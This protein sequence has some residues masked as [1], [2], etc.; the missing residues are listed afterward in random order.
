MKTEITPGVIFGECLVDDFGTAQ[1]LGG[2]P[3]NVA[4]HLHALGVASILVSRVGRDASGQRILQRMRDW[5]MPTHG[6]LEDDAL[7]TGR[8]RVIVDARQGHRFEILPH[9]AYDAISLPVKVTDRIPWLYHGSLAVREDGPSRTTWRQLRARADWRFVDI[10]LR[11]PWWNPEILAEVMQDSSVLKCNV[12]ELEQIM[13][14][15]DLPRTSTLREAMEAV[16][17]RF[18]VR[19]VLVTQGAAGAA[20]GDETHFYEAKAVPTTVRDTVG[21]GDAFA[22]GWIWGSFREDAV[23]RR[24]QRAVEL[25]AAVCALSGA[26]PE[27]PDFYQRIVA[28]WTKED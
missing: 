8:V 26:L 2:A 13:R 24:L 25:A 20:Y 22:A 9:Q 6:V 17:R 3:F 12:E 21:A 28:R 14:T 23:E 4:Q 19:A 11:D 5:G 18:H 1:R 7:P 16:A 15:Y 10:N 27:Q